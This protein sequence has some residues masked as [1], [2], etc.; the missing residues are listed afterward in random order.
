[1][2]LNMY[3]IINVVVSEFEKMVALPVGRDACALYLSRSL[4]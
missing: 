2:L 3:K 1:M 4:E